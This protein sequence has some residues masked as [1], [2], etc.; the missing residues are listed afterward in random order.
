[1]SKKRMKKARAF[2]K[3][4]FLISFLCRFPEDKRAH[5]PPPHWN[6]SS[7]HCGADFEGIDLSEGIF[8]ELAQRSPPVYSFGIHYW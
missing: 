1:M 8:Q 4:N 2:V 3:N 5:A 6:P 7:L